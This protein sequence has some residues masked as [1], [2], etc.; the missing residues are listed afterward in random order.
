MGP[1]SPFRSAIYSENRGLISLREN[2]DVIAYLNINYCIFWSDSS[3][4][5]TFEN[6]TVLLHCYSHVIDVFIETQRCSPT[7]QIHTEVRGRSGD[8]DFGHLASLRCLSLKK[9]LIKSV[10]ILAKAY[11]LCQALE[12]RFIQLLG[13]GCL[14][15]GNSPKDVKSRP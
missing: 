9:V 11:W 10:L 2:R 14:K 7:C 13:F 3:V 12:K 6:F 1:L 5:D 8:R 15:R 4:P